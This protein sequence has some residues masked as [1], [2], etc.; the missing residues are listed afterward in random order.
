MDFQHRLQKA[1]KLARQNGRA[2]LKQIA[3]R[4][5]GYI[6]DARTMR[7]AWDALAAHGGQTPGPDGRRYRDYTS[8]ET[9]DYCRGLA[10]AVA[11]GTYEPGAE[12][13]I[14]IDKAHKPGQRPIVLCNI[15]DRVVQRAAAIVLQ[16]VLDPLFDA[17]SFGFRPG[18]SH[19]DALA[20]AE[21]LALSENR[22]IWVMDDI[23]DAFLS[24]PIQRLLQ[25]VQK[26]L[27]ADELVSF[28]TRVLPGT[29]LPGLRQGGPL[30]PLML[31]LYLHHVLDWP[32]R[33]NHP[34]WPL[35]RVADD[36]LVLGKGQKAACDAHTELRRLLLPA[37]LPLKESLGTA[38]TNLASGKP[39]SWLGLRLSKADGKLAIQIAEPSW[40]RLNEQ[41]AKAHSKPQPSLRAVLIIRGWLSQR[42]PCYSQSVRDEV[43]N[44]IELI[45]RSNGFD[46]I[47]GASSWRQL[48][49]C[50]YARWKKLQKQLRLTN[51]V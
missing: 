20:A 48:F 32:W 11:E 24:V 2:G 42:G 19:L 30:S 10:K 28:L 21:R 16:P 31:N 15:Q 14:W 50:A 22:W 38:V 45:A 40:T 23:K 8:A 51:T 35:V 6:A 4:L 26:Y 47:P 5:F 1:I 41:L 36:L 18:R 17:R 12:R 7:L 43:V 37:G 27:Y 29:A 49:Q 13:I 46:E 44:R 39:A 33:R 25:I 9:W 34:K 3:A